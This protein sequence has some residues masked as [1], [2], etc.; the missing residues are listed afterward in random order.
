MIICFKLSCWPS[1]VLLRYAQS[2][3]IPKQPGTEMPFM[4]APDDVNNLFDLIEFF[5]LF[6]T[7]ILLT[8][9]LQALAR[10]E[11]IKV[12]FCFFLSAVSKPKQRQFTG[13]TNSSPVRVSFVLSTLLITAEIINS[14][15]SSY[16]W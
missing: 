7:V 15:P 2:D 4:E 9:H 6:C 12:L 14:L 1:N 13:N 8:Y 10:K 3:P 5:G 11:F 16:L